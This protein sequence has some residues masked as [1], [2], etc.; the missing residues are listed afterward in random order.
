LSVALVLMALGAAMTLGSLYLGVR[1]SELSGATQYGSLCQP[2]GRFARLGSELLTLLLL[3]GVSS[4]LLRLCSDSLE[5]LLP[6]SP[7]TIFLTPGAVVAMLSALIVLPLSL[8]SALL[9]LQNSS[10]VAIAGLVYIVGIL[11]WYG[12]HGL[13]DPAALRVAPGDSPPSETAGAWMSPSW[14]ATFSSLP[15]MIYALGCQIQAIPVFQE[16]PSQVRHPGR[17]T[18][19]VA[20]LTLLTTGLCFTIA[21]MFGVFAF[22]RVGALSGDVVSDLPAGVASQIARGVLAVSSTCVLPLL[23]WPM[24][25]AVSALLV[26]GGCSSRFSE[27]G[28][29]NEDQDIAGLRRTLSHDGLTTSLLEAAIDE[30]SLL[31]SSTDSLGDIQGGVTHVGGVGVSRGFAASPHVPLHAPKDRAVPEHDSASK[32][33]WRCCCEP[34]MWRRVWVSG[35]ILLLALVIALAV[36]S[37]KVVFQV[38]GATGASVMFFVMPPMAVIRLA[39]WQDGSTGPLSG[40]GR[41]WSKSLQKMAQQAR[42]SPRVT[43]CELVGA[44]SVLLV[45]GGV[46]LASTILVV[47]QLASG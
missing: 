41:R 40:D 25:R 36:P 4:S 37:I 12:G 8:S 24:R 16:M 2:F 5:A 6:S 1:A 43:G 23:I 42:S 11:L 15:V 26:G 35:T 47:M 9:F 22:G 29:A 10:Y 38:V 7:S 3:I 31:N 18:L 28:A 21:G 20:G 27:T 13:S 17:F 46:G 33:L 19:K 44:Y 34:T 39:S 32:R 30:D 14:S 45:G